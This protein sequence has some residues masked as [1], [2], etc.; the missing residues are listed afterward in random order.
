MVFRAAHAAAM[1][2]PDLVPSMV[3][4]AYSPPGQL[5]I[6]KYCD[7]IRGVS[8][9]GLPRLPWLSSRT[10]ACRPRWRLL[11]DAEIEQGDLKAE[12]INEGEEQ[13]SQ[14]TVYIGTAGYASAHLCDLL[15]RVDNSVREARS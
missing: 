6:T 9:T 2:A 10:C 3:G 4:E 14:A 11:P 5:L 15:H 13:S 12:L 7:F 8:C 1:G